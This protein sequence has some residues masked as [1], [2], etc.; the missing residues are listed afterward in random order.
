MSVKSDVP[1]FYVAFQRC[2][3]VYG[4]AE[5]ECCGRVVDPPSSRL[6]A[7]GLSPSDKCN[8]KDVIVKGGNRVVVPIVERVQA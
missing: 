1:T 6:D 2:S 3:L 4:S 8:Q 7:R 5:H